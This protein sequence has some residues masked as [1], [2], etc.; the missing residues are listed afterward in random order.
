[1]KVLKETGVE[2]RLSVIGEQFRDAPEVFDWAKDFF[3][4]EIDRW[5]YQESLA[6]YRAALIEADIVV[7][8]ANHEFFG[9]SMVEAIAAGAYPVLPKRL[10]Y[11]EITAGIETLFED[12][13]FY[14]GPVK[15]LVDKL[16]ELIN[17]TDLWQGDVNRGV[18]AMER[19]MWGIR[20]KALD[21]SLAE[22]VE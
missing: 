8:T 12:E 1:M 2:F 18:S 19:Y 17:R 20:A 15:G 9:I 14:D 10:A 22:V 3:A 5:G 7:S 16:T 11:P 6:E 13:F 21:D 4:D